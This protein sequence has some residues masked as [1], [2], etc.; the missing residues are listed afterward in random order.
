MKIQQITL[1]ALTL[2]LAACGNE[3]ILE[4]NENGAAAKVPMTF[5]A[6]EAQTRTSLGEDGHVVNWT[7][8][9]RVAIYDGTNELCPFNVIDINGSTAT[10]TGQAALTETYTAFYPQANAT[11]I[12]NEAITFTLPTTQTAKSGSFGEGMNPSWAQTTKG[13]N[14]FQFKNLGALVKFTVGEDGFSGISAL[15]LSSNDG[16]DKL[17][18]SMTYTIDAESGQGTL[19]AND[20]ASTTV[21]L[22]GNFEVGQQYYFVVAPG[23]M[24]KGILMSYKIGDVTYQLV[25]A[26]QVNFE[27][28]K[29]TNLG[30]LDKGKFIQAF[31]NTALIKAVEEAVRDIGWMV[32]PDGSVTLTDE[33]KEKIEAV[34][35]LSLL[36]KELSDLSGIELFSNLTYL[37][38]SRNKLTTL[39]VSKLTKLNTLDCNR[40]ELNTLI[41]GTGLTQLT[42]LD[43]NTNMS[44]AKLDISSLT[45]LKVLDCSLT[46]LETLD[47][48]GLK[49]LATL[50]CRHCQLTRL[51]VSEQAELTT[52]QCHENRISELDITHNEKLSRLECG[53]QTSNGVAVQELTLHLP[54]SLGYAFW[55]KMLELYASHNINVKAILTDMS[56]GHD[57][58]EDSDSDPVFRDIQ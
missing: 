11:N 24:E 55:T 41:F 14:T 38:C 5:T 23:T 12:T 31:T 45:A 32:N 36:G 17:A 54:S 22:N 3:E 42:T 4:N 40:N 9:D 28:G 29:I 52:L 49:S 57:S 37:D 58:F 34:T 7:E 43:C 30:T 8:G 46:R 19:A 35:K 13:G 50:T 33:N 1:A 26:N 15:T 10:L 25:T 39:D 16:A 51:N 18:G 44:L 48:K 53:S 20:G 21:T 2:L 6:E 47:L 56:S 27:A